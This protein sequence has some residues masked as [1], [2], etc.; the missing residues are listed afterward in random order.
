M[1]IRH[2]LPHT[3][4]HPQERRAGRPSSP[5][6]H[7]GA[8]L[9]YQHT[10]RK[11]ELWPDEAGRVQVSSLPGS[12][13]PTSSQTNAGLFCHK[14]TSAAIKHVFVGKKVP[15]PRNVCVNV[16]Q[17]K[18][19]VPNPPPNPGARV[20]RCEL[21]LTY[22]MRGTLKGQW[23]LIPSGSGLEQFPKSFAF[24]ESRALCFFFFFQ[25]HVYFSRNLIPRVPTPSHLHQ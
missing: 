21:T 19:G 17:A 16:R 3:T 22:D 20:A 11:A 2:F 7:R 4:A 14:N 9:A 1:R 13:D 12:L 18:T 8:A 5:S 25:K 23:H 24:P 6:A 10:S 15:R